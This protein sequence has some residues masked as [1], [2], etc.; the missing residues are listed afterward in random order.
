MKHPATLLGLLFMALC[1]F[2]GDNTVTNES[3]AAQRERLYQRF[4][5]EMRED[6]SKIDT[7]ANSALD[8]PFTR[9]M[10][11][12]MVVHPSFGYRW[13][14]VPSPTMTGSNAMT[15]ID[16]FIA[17]NGWDMQKDGVVFLSVMASDKSKPM[18][19]LPWK[20]VHDRKFPAVTHDGILYVWFTG[21]HYNDRGVAYNPKTNMFAR[22]MSF[23][24]VGQHWY[25]WA[26]SDSGDYGPHEY[27]GAKN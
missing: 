27:E 14:D 2:A 10:F 7:N 4:L 1:A 21:W 19:G 23:K 18:S 26:T 17:T 8:T 12:Q 15:E 20:T 24:P 11:D 9:R 6:M 13:D 16:S 3:E 25:V 22:G 5:R